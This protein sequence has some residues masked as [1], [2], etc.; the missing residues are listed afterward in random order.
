MSQESTPVEK[1]DLWQCVTC[2]TL[3]HSNSKRRNWQ[4]D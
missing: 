4:A 2:A 3:D 1:I